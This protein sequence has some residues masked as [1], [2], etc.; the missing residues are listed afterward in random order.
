MRVELSPQKLVPLASMAR[1]LR[2]TTAWLRAEAEAG[3]VP[4]LKAG[5]RYLFV[6]EI[7]EA[8]LLKRAA[9]LP[10]GTVPHAQ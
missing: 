4:S 5:E 1:R 8:E 3:R 7:V 10:E 6:P 2:V 9:A